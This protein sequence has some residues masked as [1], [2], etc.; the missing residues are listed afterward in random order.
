MHGG[1]PTVMA[2]VPLPKEYTEE[3]CVVLLKLIE[4][5]HYIDKYI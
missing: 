5:D 1:G 2:G 3:V 4:D